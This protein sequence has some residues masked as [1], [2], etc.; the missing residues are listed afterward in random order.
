[1]HSPKVPQHLFDHLQDLIRKAKGFGA[2]AADGVYV[3]SMGVS[4]AIRNGELSTLERSESASLGLRVLIGKKQACVATHDIH[5]D[6]LTD[7]VERAVSMAKLA[8]E[9]PYAGL[10]EQSQLA[11]HIP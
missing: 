1:M 10:A 7:M 2:D 11:T 4:A 3:E 5:P 6:R 8:P 9:D